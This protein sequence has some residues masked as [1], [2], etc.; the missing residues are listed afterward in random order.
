MEPGR[1]RDVFLDESYAPAVEFFEIRDREFV[2]AILAGD[3][4]KAGA[5]RSGALRER[6]EAHRA[7][8]D[9]TVKLAQT[10]AVASEENAATAIR[11]GSWVFFAA[12]AGLLLVAALLGSNISG[13][14]T[15]PLAETVTV[16]EAVAQGDLTRHLDEH[17][18]DEMGTLARAT[19]RAVASMRATIASIAENAQALAGASEELASVS[20][21]MSGN[22]E[23]TFAQASVVSAA[24]EQVSRNIQTV[25]TGAD[26]MNAS[27]K[28]IAKN[29]TEAARVATAAV[30][31]AESTN[32][33][34]ERL[35]DSSTE[36]GKVIRVITSIAEQTNLLALN[37]RIEAARAGESGK[38]FAVV[39]NEV[40]E[41]AKETAKATEDISRKIQAIQTDATSA[42]TA[43]ADIGTI[44]T[45][46]NDISNT[47]AS[48]VE[49]QSATTNEIGRNVAEAAKGSSEI[50]QNIT[51]VAQ[52][53]ASTNSGAN[54]AQ[55]AASELARMASDLQ[56]LVGGF[57][58]KREGAMQPRSAAKRDDVATN[59]AA[60]HWLGDSASDAPL[61]H[62]VA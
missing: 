35:G 55:Q 20:T 28:E 3:R 33:T 29:A 8:I 9:E 39:A 7:K 50:A 60:G 27:I 23:E 56:S 15:R 53:A 2:P 57:K 5:I 58:F 59:G 52:A 11:H 36:I 38:G 18:T 14:I 41:L 44:I 37:A 22:A 26:E 17:S 16:L 21:Q 43:I 34:M 51:G 13:G 10:Q 49:E 1:L 25:S 48:A 47:I 30:A 6:Y 31:A 32:A 45:Q 40:K 42:V 4:G 12:V 19:N 24:S 54:D 46:I 62:G 61:A